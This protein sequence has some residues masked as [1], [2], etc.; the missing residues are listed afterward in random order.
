MSLAVAV[1]FAR[2]PR[3]GVGK[4][5]LAREAGDRAALN[6]ARHN[7]LRLLRRLR[8]LRGVELVLAAAPDHH[9]RFA[10][11]GF[12]RIGQGR[13]DLGA[14]MQRV[15]NRFPRRR[16][17]LVGSDIPGIQAEDIRAALHRLRG[18]AA[19]FGPAADGGYWLVGLSGRRV[20]AP[21]ARVR[22]SSPYALADT[23]CNLPRR[24]A[25]FLRRL[26]DVDDAASLRAAMLASPLQR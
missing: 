20:A 14:R 26:S 3:L 5:R 9:A 22:W 4:R 7:L 11:P 13:G 2:I 8:G 19:V 12:R 16:V 1:V 24:E 18:A 10:A 21:F 17:V 23:L 6:F 15:F 25:A